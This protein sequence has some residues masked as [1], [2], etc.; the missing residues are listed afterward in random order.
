[1]PQRGALRP[2]GKRD[3]A[4]DRRPGRGLAQQPRLPCADRSVAGLRGRA[5]PRLSL[6]RPLWFARCKLAPMLRSIAIVLGRGLA[7]AA[8]R[9]S[10]QP[11]G[12]AGV[13]YHLA[14]LQDG[15]PKYNVVARNVPDMEHC[16]AALEAMRIRFLNLGG[17]RSA[18][19][20]AYQGTF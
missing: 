3:A 11:P 1:A 6:A 7:L 15:K 12:D 5:R 2:L 20:A 14:D 19:T 18:I 8:C 13:C 16:A 17:G 10:L 4:A 9:Q